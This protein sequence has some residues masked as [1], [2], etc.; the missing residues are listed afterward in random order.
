MPSERYPSRYCPD[1][2]RPK[3]KR[4]LH[5]EMIESKSLNPLFSCIC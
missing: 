4:E 2:H 5:D 3:S 1:G